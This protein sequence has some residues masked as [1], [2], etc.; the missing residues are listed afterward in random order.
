MKCQKDDCDQPATFHITEL[1]EGKPVEYH[2]CEDCAKHYLTEAPADESETPSLAG[3]LAQQLAIGQ[4][5]EELAR[6]DQKVCPVCGHEFQGI[7]A[8]VC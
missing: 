7:L 3:A 1:L 5:A 2:L 4:T 8:K 6:L